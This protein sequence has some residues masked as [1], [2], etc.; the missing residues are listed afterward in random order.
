VKEPNAHSGGCAPALPHWHDEQAQLLQT[1]VMKRIDVSNAR[2]ALNGYQKGK[3]F[4]C[5]DDISVV[6]GAI[7]IC[8]VDHFLPHQNKRVHLPANINGVWNLVLACKKCNGSGEKGGK[9]PEKSCLEKLS[10]RNEYYISS[11]HPLAETI[12]NQTGTNTTQRNGFLMEQ[13]NKSLEDSLHTWKP[14]YIY[15]C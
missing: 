4:Y 14:D 11:K 10:T 1:D 7:S 8:Q 15:P 13:Y 6:T 3:C 5:C 12:V 2:D 9:I